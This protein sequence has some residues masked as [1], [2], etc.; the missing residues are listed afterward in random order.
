MV[1]ININ[2]TEFISLPLWCHQ[3]FIPNNQLT[4]AVGG[5]VLYKFADET[6]KEMHRGTQTAAMIK[7][8]SK[9][10]RLCGTRKVLL[11]YPCILL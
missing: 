8:L 6:E 2:R 11:I 3:I 9:Y 1:D 4:I 7:M 5:G 10:K